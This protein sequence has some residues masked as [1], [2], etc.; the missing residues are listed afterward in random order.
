MFW[1]DYTFTIPTHIFVSL[2]KKQD[3]LFKWRCGSLRL[4]I[5]KMPHK[6]T[7]LVL[8]S[9]MCGAWARETRVMFMM[10]TLTSI[11]FHISKGH[12]HT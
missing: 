12:N 11:C 4:C 6:A 10:L 2:V 3:K 9:S 8:S 1:A 5:T 7:F